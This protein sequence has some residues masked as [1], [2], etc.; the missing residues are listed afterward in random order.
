[1]LYLIR[2]AD[3]I[4]SEPDAERP[5]SPKGI[6][7]AALMGEAVR[8][9]QE[10][11]P[12]EIWTSPLK[13]AEETTEIL[14]EHL[15]WE[16]K[17][18]VVSELEPEAAPQ[19]IAARLARFSGTLA[20]VGHNPHLTMLTTLLVTGR[21]DFPVLVVGKCAFLALEPVRG[22]GLGGWNLAWHLTPDSVP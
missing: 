12:D 1:M 18:R 19:T 22:R 9:R 3:A 11:V 17:R 6:A 20:I 10:L 14:C 16:A 13:R 15:G 21:F 5:L 2:H 8:Q 4:D 7:Q